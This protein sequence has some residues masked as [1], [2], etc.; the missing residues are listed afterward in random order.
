M[1]KQS[2]KILLKIS[3]SVVLVYENKHAFKHKVSSRDLKNIN[4]K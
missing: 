1:I 3:S 2:K 4:T